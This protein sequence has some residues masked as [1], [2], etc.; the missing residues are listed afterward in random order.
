MCHEEPLQPYA[1][2]VTYCLA[3]ILT[4][5]LAVYSTMPKKKEPPEKL[6]YIEN[7][8]I[9]VLFTYFRKSKENEKEANFEAQKAEV[10]SPEDESYTNYEVNDK[11]GEHEEYEGDVK[12]EEDEELEKYQDLEEDE[13]YDDDDEYEVDEEYEDDGDFEEDSLQELFSQVIRYC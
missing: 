11:D 1:S 8:I 4:I 12:Y 6:I 13:V 3:H 9:T 10:E 2:N 7:L 5:L